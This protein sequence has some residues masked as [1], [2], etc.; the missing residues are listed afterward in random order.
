MRQ[1]EPSWL[2]GELKPHK[3]TWQQVSDASVLVQNTNTSKT[4]SVKAK[5][6]PSRKKKDQPNELNYYTMNVR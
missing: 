4:G 3:L 2:A 1:I 6:M 5:E